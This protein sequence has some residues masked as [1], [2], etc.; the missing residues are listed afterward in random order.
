MTTWSSSFDMSTY[1]TVCYT[2]GTWQL[3]RI[4]YRDQSRQVE[5]LRL[6]S[7]WVIL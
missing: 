4:A 1:V 7:T 5:P 6:P 2:H 3:A